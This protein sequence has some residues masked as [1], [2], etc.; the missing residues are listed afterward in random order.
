ML[1]SYCILGLSGFIL[2]LIFIFLFRRIALRYNILVLHQTPL[3]GGLS[4]GLAFSLACLVSILFYGTLTKEIFGIILASSIML[5]LG[6]IDDLKELSILAKILTQLIATSILIIFGIR[7]QIVYI[8]SILNTIITFIWILGITNAFNHLDIMDGLCGGIALIVSLGFLFVSM[9]NHQFNVA[10][11]S[12]VL[13]S[14]I[15][16][17]LLYNLP[18]AKVYLGNAGSHFLGFVLAAST[19]II[20]YAPLERKIAL[21]SPILILGFPIFDTG[22]LILMRLRQNKSIFKKSDDHLALRF[23]SKGYSKNKTLVFMSGI[24][25]FFCISG[26]LLSQAS[27]ILG[28]III[29]FVVMVSLK[30]TQ[31]MGRIIV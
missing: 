16:G 26:V 2:S 23:L 22:F 20:S 12:W 13:V 24:G 10:M 3:I 30:I 8:G 31:R 9:F 19:L 1:I 6:I 29:L 17:F 27:N 18:V 7:T 25:L 4:I 28:L 11:L 14:A 15:I 5:I 21:L